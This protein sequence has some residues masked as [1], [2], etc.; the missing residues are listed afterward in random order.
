[1]ATPDFL[2]WLEREEEVFGMTGAIERTIDPDACRR[3]LLEELG[4]DPS[5]KQVGAMYEAGRMRYETLPTIGVSTSQVSYP[6]G[7]QTWY[8]DL[9]TGRRVGTADVQYRIDLMGF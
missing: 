7:K 2:K 8:R 3:M 6:W 1:M 5:D 9:T 4:Y